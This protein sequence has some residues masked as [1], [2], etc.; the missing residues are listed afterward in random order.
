M[1]RKY[2]CDL[3]G[4]YVVYTTKSHLTSSHER[5]VKRK[6]NNE[7]KEIDKC[8]DVVDNAKAQIHALL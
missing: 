2:L 5:K 8:A 7:R 3:N 1:R 6:T 4:I